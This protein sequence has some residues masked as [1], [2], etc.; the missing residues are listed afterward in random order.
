MEFMLINELNHE[1][2]SEEELE[3]PNE[4]METRIV[5]LAEMRKE[6]FEQ[7]MQRPL[8]RGKRWL[9][10]KIRDE[11]LIRPEKRDHKLQERWN[12]LAAVMWI[13]EKGTVGVQKSKY[14]PE[15]V[16]AGHKVK[17]YWGP[18]AEFPDP[19]AATDQLGQT[20]KRRTDSIEE[21]G[22]KKK[23]QKQWVGLRQRQL[24]KGS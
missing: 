12:E 13:G 15:K 8:T 7:S 6:H 3:I 14:Q 1:W 10:L 9:D 4:Q 16:L 11:V 23:H 5:R 21:G 22:D 24:M 20:E 18:E 2:S 17:M 19:I